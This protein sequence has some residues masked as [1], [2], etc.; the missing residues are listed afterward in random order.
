[1]TAGSSTSRTPGTQPAARL[2]VLTPPRT[3]YHSAPAAGQMTS[4]ARL[5]TQKQR[6][7]EPK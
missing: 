6:S 4:P 5:P 1:M 3:A 2:L 7:A